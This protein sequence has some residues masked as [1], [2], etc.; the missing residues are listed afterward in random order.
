[1]A[2][3]TGNNGSIKLSTA[4]GGAVNATAI[5]AVRNFSVELTRDT[6]ETTVMTNDQRTYITGMSQW[7]GSADIYFDSSGTAPG[8]LSTYPI[9]NPT[10]GTVGQGTVAIELYLDGTGGK[11]NGN[12]IITGFTVN[13]SMDGMVEASISFQGSG[14]CTFTA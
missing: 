14:A 3:L 5:A 11:F 12:I 13:A 4:V 7:S 8:H 1:M 2:T 10:Q 6:I 9:L